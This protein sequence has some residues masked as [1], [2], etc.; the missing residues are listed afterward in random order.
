M[1]T[2]VLL[3]DGYNLMHA[4]GFAQSDYAPKELL[5]CRTRLL[6]LLLKLLTKA[7][8]SET[9]IIFDARD[10]PRFRASQFNVSGLT[11]LF[12][13]PVGDADAEI[14]RWISRHKSPA[15][16]TLVSS[17]RMLQRAARGYGAKFVESQK[18]LTNLHRRTLPKPKSTLCAD[19]AEKPSEATA[20]Y[21]MQFFGDI[22]IP[23][24][25][26]TASAEPKIEQSS[27]APIGPAQSRSNDAN[28]KKSGGDED[29]RKEEPV[30]LDSA[31]LQEW[32]Q[33]F[34][35]LS[36][37]IAKDRT[38]PTVQREQELEEWLKS[39]LDEENR[40]G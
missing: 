22:E 34:G 6:T 15:R 2:P 8:V 35:E 17:D 38:E 9:T 12:A 31:A 10:P 3:I 1:S 16:I 32:L 29:R 19:D 14:Q 36:A 11:V 20:E 24:D 27:A 39:H 7:E 33:A 23:D 25:E 28:R 26:S 30:E 21:W 40:R 18:F 37:E 13:N 5:R 4:A